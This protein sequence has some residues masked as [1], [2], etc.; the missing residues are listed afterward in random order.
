MAKKATAGKAKKGKF[1]AAAS[2]F[3]FGANKAGSKEKRRS[4]RFKNG[5]SWS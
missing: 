2:S 3:N 5:G 1:A 4:G